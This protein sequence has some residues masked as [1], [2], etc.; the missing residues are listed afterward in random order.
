MLYTLAGL[1]WL[2]LVFVLTFKAGQVHRKKRNIKMSENNEDNETD[3]SEIHRLHAEYGEEFGEDAL[4]ELLARSMLAVV[5][6]GPHG[7]SVTRIE[8][9]GTVVAMLEGCTVPEGFNL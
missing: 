7:G 5:S 4:I 3:V 2:A 9:A 1:A 6:I 8:D